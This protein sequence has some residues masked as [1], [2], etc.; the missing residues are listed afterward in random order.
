M[1]VNASGGTINKGENFTVTYPAG[2]LTGVTYVTL[3][4][5]YGNIA[6]TNINV[7]SDTELTADAPDSGLVHGEIISI[8]FT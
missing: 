4:T 1:A 7:T 2:G 8:G 3:I 6:C 5:S